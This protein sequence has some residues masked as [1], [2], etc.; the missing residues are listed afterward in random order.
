MERQLHRD[1]GM[2][3]AVKF[4]RSITAKIF[5]SLTKQLRWVNTDIHDTEDEHEYY[6]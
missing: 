2:R 1:E 6:A 5:H 3:I 4:H